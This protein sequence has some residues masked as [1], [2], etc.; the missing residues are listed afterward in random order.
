MPDIGV[1]PACYD[2]A[3]RQL[4]LDWFFMRSASER[5]PS[6]DDDQD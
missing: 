1:D 3:S 5:T 4:G 6:D 2:L